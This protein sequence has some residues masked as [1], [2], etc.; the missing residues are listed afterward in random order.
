MTFTSLGRGSATPAEG[1]AA[2]EESGVDASE[3]ASDP[4]PPEASVTAIAPWVVLGPFESPGEPERR[5][6]PLREAKLV[7][8]WGEKVRGRRWTRTRA[9]RPWIDVP[10]AGATA[11]KLCYVGTW[12]HASRDTDIV[13]WVTHRGGIVASVGASP[14]YE[15]RV[16]SSNA[17]CRYPSA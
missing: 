16:A 15:R 3:R 2:E 9:E 7:P 6:P 14:V 8:A 10:S 13:L 4:I 1:E 12:L 11:H 17:R 5:K